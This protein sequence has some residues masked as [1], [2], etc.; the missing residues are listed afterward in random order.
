MKLNLGCGK[1][2]RNGYLNIDWYEDADKRINLS[3][4][5]YPFKENSV[6]EIL[7]LNILEHLENPYD[8]L[9]E[10]HRICKPGAKIILKV[11]HF[12]SGNAWADLQHKRPF[13]WYCFQNEDLKPFFKNIKCKITFPYKIQKP[14]EWFVN[15]APKF[16][17][18]Y[19]SGIIR[20]GDIEVELIVKE[21]N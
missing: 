21:K 14:L 19:F 6:T 10:W 12:A 9:L 5:P 1:D 7:A 4:I 11:P 18:Y 8:I 3:K 15:Q 2:K 20:S 16:W 17:E 13:S